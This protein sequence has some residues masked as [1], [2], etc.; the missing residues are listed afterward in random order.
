MRTQGSLRRAVTEADWLTGTRRNGHTLL[1]HNQLQI[2]SLARL[3]PL[4]E[5]FFNYEL[6]EFHEFQSFFLTQR[7]KGREEIAICSRSA[8]SFSICQSNDALRSAICGRNHY[9]QMTQMSQMGGCSLWWTLACFVVA[10]ASSP[11]TRS[12]RGRKGEEWG[13]RACESQTG[14]P[15]GQARRGPGIGGEIA[16]RVCSARGPC[17]VAGAWRGLRS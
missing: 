11:A 15:A 6:N 14:S 10:R 1:G 8:G 12:G 16:G 9:P 17:G 2:S 13:A 4:G 3:V 5:H 7:R